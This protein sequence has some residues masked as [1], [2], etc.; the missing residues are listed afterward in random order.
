VAEF[1]ILDSDHH[2]FGWPKNGFPG[3]QVLHSHVNLIPE[4]EITKI[5][6]TK[7]MKMVLLVSGGKIKNFAVVSQINATARVLILSESEDVMK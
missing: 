7:L 4:N 6:Y 1:T 5:N 2:P 3:P